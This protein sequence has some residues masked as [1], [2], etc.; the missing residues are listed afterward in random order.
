MSYIG[1]ARGF[2]KSAREIEQRLRTETL[3]PEERARLE[4]QR[5]WFDEESDH[6]WRAALQEARRDA[7]DERD[8]R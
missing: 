4:R 7:D 8:G 2:R 1:E 3:S 6:S 5:Q